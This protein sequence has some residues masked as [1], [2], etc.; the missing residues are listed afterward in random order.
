MQFI[1]AITLLLI[2]ASCATLPEEYVFDNQETFGANTD[3][4]RE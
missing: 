3:D 1:V 4:M 2:L